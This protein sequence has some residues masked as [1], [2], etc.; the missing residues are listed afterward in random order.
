MQEITIAGEV[1]KVAPRYS[2]GHIL[3]DKEASALNQTFFNN[4]RNNMNTKVRDSKKGGSFDIDTAQNEVTK[5]SNEYAFGSRRG[6]VS[7]K[8]P[9][10]TIALGLATT[11]IRG[12]LKEKFGKDHGISPTDVK[13]LATDLVDHPVK[14]KTYIESAKLIHGLPDT[15]VLGDLEKAA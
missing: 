4:I 12:Q 2:E 14:G 11:K 15:G 6:P 13:K 8:D 9:V 7:T 10:R 3:N 1:F 5:Y